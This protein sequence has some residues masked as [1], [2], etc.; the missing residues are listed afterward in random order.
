MYRIAV[1]DD[2]ARIVNTL[3]GFLERFAQS[4]GLEF[5]IIAFDSANSLLESYPQNLDL[6]FLDIA[7]DGINGMEAARHI[8]TFDTNV[9]IIFITTMSQYAIDGY[10]VRAFGFIKKP[11]SEAQLKHELI[12][13]LSQIDSNRSKES[14]LNLRD[15]N[16]I[17]R[18]PISHICYC[19]VVNH[20]VLLTMDDGQT[21]KY[22]ST[23]AYLEEQ[24]ADAG[25]FRCHSSFLV[26]GDCI[27]EIAQTELV[28]KNGGVVP[29]SQR[30]R[31]DFMRQISTYLGG[32]I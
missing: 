2:E 9:C 23:M 8:R 19:E 25:F 28:M 32:K 21:N 15:G 20:Y 26:N 1:C 22:R 3:R 16:T 6:L 30:R 13:A 29:I 14:Y 27:A 7:M 31:R 10:E 5:E 12:C 24:L 17:H 11:V 4:R 18:V